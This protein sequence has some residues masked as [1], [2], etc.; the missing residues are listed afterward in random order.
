MGQNQFKDLELEFQDIL[1]DEP[2]SPHLK[3]NNNSFQTE[4]SNKFSPKVITSNLKHSTLLINPAWIVEFKNPNS[5]ELIEEE[6]NE[7]HDNIISLRNIT[8][9]NHAL[10]FTGFFLNT[11]TES[12]SFISLKNSP[13]TCLNLEIFSNP[14]LQDEN[15]IF[16]TDLISFSKDDLKAVIEVY[17]DIQEKIRID[18]LANNS[19][20]RGDIKERQLLISKLKQQKEKIGSIESDHLKCDMEASNHNLKNSNFEITSFQT[21]NKVIQNNNLIINEF[22]NQLN[23]EA[24]P[25]KNAIN[26]NKNEND[27]IEPSPSVFSYFSLCKI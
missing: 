27:L 7:E 25:S 10:E 22:R 6:N 11:K 19:R 9:V 16:F 15:S 18:E 13:F 14:S 5:L 21:S 12:K 24:S 4:T 3:I 17:E 8:N 26:E 20:F 1:A 23:I 2:A